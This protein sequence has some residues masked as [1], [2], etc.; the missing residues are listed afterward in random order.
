M[1]LQNMIFQGDRAVP[2]TGATGGIADHM[3]HPYRRAITR[4]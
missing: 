4:G 1:I 2:I 3:V